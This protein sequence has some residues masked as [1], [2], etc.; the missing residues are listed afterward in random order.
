ML[1]PPGGALALA[2]WAQK[3]LSLAEI[4]PEWLTRISDE[5]DV[6]WISK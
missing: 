1:S 2:R 5:K 6:P 3:D 4:N